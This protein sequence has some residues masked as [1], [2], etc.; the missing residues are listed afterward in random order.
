[1]HLSA[2]WE[3]VWVAPMTLPLLVYGVLVYRWSGVRRGRRAF[4]LFAMASPLLWLLFVLTAD[5]VIDWAIA[6][7]H[8]H[9]DFG[10]LGHYA[11]WLYGSRALAVLGAIALT[12]M[13]R[14]W[15]VGVFVWAAA[16]LIWFVSPRLI[17]RE[18]LQAAQ[19]GEISSWHAGYWVAG[20]SAV[21]CHGVVGAGMFW[22]ARGARRVA[23]D[24]SRC[25]HCGYSLV[26]L[27]ES[28]S[29]A[30]CPECGAG[31]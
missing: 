17:T 6:R 13:T 9:R 22:W 2:I 26:G 5:W 16:L 10:F 28:G 25:H 15:R 23:L 3:T 4:L 14:S 11:G 29:G 31:L 8:L 18:V 27:P 12:T 7:G 30:Q 19:R 21:M 20:L 1:M 24:P